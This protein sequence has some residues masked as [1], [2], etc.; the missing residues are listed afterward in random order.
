MKTI[1]AM[2]V[3]VGLLLTGGAVFA[4]EAGQ[5]DAPQGKLRIGIGVVKILPSLKDQLHKN[6]QGPAVSRAIETIDGQ[7]MDALQNTRKFEIIARSDLDVLMR[8]QGLPAGAIIDPNDAKAAAPGKIKGIQ[9]LI[10]PTIDDFVD[11]AQSS[12]SQEMGMAVSRRTIRLSAVVRIYNST[13]GVLFESMSVP[14]Q[15]ENAGVTR[16]TPGTN[17]PNPKATDDSVYVELINQLATRIGQRVTDTLYPAKVL[18]VTGDQV[19][20]NRG[21][22]TAINRGEVWDVY[23]QGTSLKDPDTGEVLGREEVHVG[24]V[25]ISQILPKYSLAQIVGENRGVTTGM[26]LRQRL[27]MPQEPGQPA[28]QPQPLAPPAGP[29]PVPA[30]VPAPAAPAR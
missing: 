27:Q 13:T 12:Y 1:I 29:A 3:A 26:V 19:T 16:V 8:E 20:L 24:Q 25:L 4:Q 10:L 17:S 21:A 7:L 15:I 2:I 5:P 6:D 14:V 28:S 30:S 9:F 18:A 11:T 23:A 22:G